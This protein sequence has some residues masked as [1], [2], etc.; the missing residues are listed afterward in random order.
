MRKWILVAVIV[1][2]VAALL[3]FKPWHKEGPPKDLTATVRRGDISD[4]V[5]A[6]GTLEPS[7][8]VQV[9]AQVTGQLKAL[10][11]TLGDRVAKGDLIAEIDSI[12]QRNDLRVARAALAEAEASLK[13]RQYQL[14]K[15]E[16]TLKRQR[17]LYTGNAG[18]GADFDDAEIAV[19]V[20]R[21]DL[22]LAKA[23][24]E[25][26]TVEV[27]KAEANLGYTRIVAPMDGR[28]LALAVKAG[29]TLSAAQTI[30]V[31]GVI[32]ET[33]TMTVRAQVSEADVAKIKP[34]QKL[35]FNT[36]GDR[37]TRHESTVRKVEPAPTSILTAG[38]EGLSSASSQSTTSQAVYFNV[39]FDAPNQG[40]SLM[41]MMTAEVH[42][43][44]AA[45]EK[46]LIAPMSAFTG[47]GAGGLY[48]AR[49]RGPDGKVVERKVKLGLTNQVEGEILEGVKEGEVLLLS[50]GMEGPGTV[51]AV[52]VDMGGD[53]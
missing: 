25:R 24:I 48:R 14:D 21:A 44:T 28:V 33:D 18:S 39:L 8:L 17:T 29:Q 37:R 12:Q 47:P 6:T 13:S 9:G 5:S 30:P 1:A 27:E 16:R 49:L 43:T 42:I 35:W 31:I 2:T 40:G 4:T 45:V 32:A 36:L 10:H 7:K 3:W 52:D 20:A 11:V 19:D 15:A 23:Q 38:Q 46:A 53:E 51:P 41:P 34:G 22:A 26:A 50:T